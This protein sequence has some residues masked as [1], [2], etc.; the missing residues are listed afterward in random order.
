MV[1]MSPRKEY[2]PDVM[3]FDDGRID[4]NRVFFVDEVFARVQDSKS[5]EAL[6]PIGE[7]SLG[8]SD[9]EFVQ[10]VIGELD[11]SCREDPKFLVNISTRKILKIKLPRSVPEGTMNFITNEATVATFFPGVDRVPNVG[12]YQATIQLIPRQ[13][14][15]AWE[16]CQMLMREDMY[17]GSDEEVD[18]E[19]ASTKVIR[20]TKSNVLIKFTHRDRQASDPGD[21]DRRDG[22]Q[23]PQI[24]GS[25][26]AS[27]STSSMPITPRGSESPKPPGMLVDDAIDSSRRTSGDN[28]GSEYDADTESLPEYEFADHHL[29]WSTDPNHNPSVEQL[30]N[31]SKKGAVRP[32]DVHIIEELLGLGQYSSPTTLFASGIPHPNPFLVHDR[33]TFHSVDCPLL[34]FKKSHQVIPRPPTPHPTPACKGCNPD[35]SSIPNGTS[36]TDK[37]LDSIMEDLKN[38][39]VENTKNSTTQDTADRLATN[40]EF[41]PDLRNSNKSRRLQPGPLYVVPGSP[42]KHSVYQNQTISTDQFIMPSLFNIPASNPDKRDARLV[43]TPEDLLPP[44]ISVAFR[45]FIDNNRD[46]RLED[47]TL[48]L[49]FVHVFLFKVAIEICNQEGRISYLEKNTTFRAMWKECPRMLKYVNPVECDSPFDLVHNVY[50][51]P[52]ER[53]SIQQ[54]LDF[55]DSIDGLD[56]DS[57]LGIAYLVLNHL[58]N[59]RPS[60]SKAA[61]LNDRRLNGEFGHPGEYPPPP[62]FSESPPLSPRSDCSTEPFVLDDNDLTEFPDSY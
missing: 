16:G 58:L 40:V 7:I 36:Q 37:I 12:L 1:G 50:L 13:D 22:V 20:K 35:H 17:E 5:F 42:S 33:E 6:A 18:S 53:R 14:K 32:D 61:G 55:I 11:Q 51:F 43:K 3:V 34:P 54:C 2:S 48:W 24:S 10:E 29:I 47:Y 4:I 59:Y 44:D 41:D 56:C 15:F 25:S 8:M 46:I 30:E 49:R 28:N 27:D 26:E 52:S 39:S 9:V 60:P 38:L 57:D 62:G 21:H 31:G 19:K 45:I 23:E